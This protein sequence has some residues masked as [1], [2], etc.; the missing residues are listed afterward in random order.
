MSNDKGLEKKLDE[1]IKDAMKGRR[2][3]ELACLRMIKSLVSEKRTAPGFTGEVTDELVLGVISSYSRKLARAIDEF[4]KAGRDDNPVIETYR[5]EIDFLKSWLPEKLDEE[6]TRKLVRT[7][8][9]DSGLA[10][11]SASGR[12]IGMVMK[13]HREEV[14][15][16]LVKKIIQE[17]LAAD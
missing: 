2:S 15:P 3:E 10:G 6:E 14:D 17:E 13:N 4:I 16:V 7:I 11:P 9:V 1:A 8:I 12:L 5:F